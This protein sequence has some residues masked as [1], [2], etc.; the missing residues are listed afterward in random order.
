MLLQFFQL[1][2]LLLW[3]VAAV[4][5]AAASTSTSSGLLQGRVRLVP[6]TADTEQHYA[7][8]ALK[9]LSS[10]WAWRPSGID[11]VLADGAEHCYY[12][13]P[14]AAVN[15][16]YVQTARAR[17][18]SWPVLCHQSNKQI[19]SWA[20]INYS[21]GPI[22][23]QQI[24]VVTKDEQ[25]PDKQRVSNGWQLQSHQQL[26][27][28]ST[29]NKDVLHP[30]DSTIVTV[31]YT[32]SCLHRLT[33]STK[34]LAVT[35]GGTVELDLT[36][37]TGQH[38]QLEHNLNMCSMV[39]LA[40]L[41][42]WTDVHQL[43]SVLVDDLNH[44][45]PV[46]E[47]I[48]YKYVSYY[49]MYDTYGHLRYK[50][51][52][53]QGIILC[54]LTGSIW[55]F[56]LATAIA[57]KYALRD[58]WRMFKARRKF[59]LRKYK[60]QLRP[61]LKAVIQKIIPP[62]QQEQQQETVQ[63]STS[64]TGAAATASG[65]VSKKAAKRKAKAQ[66]TA[67]NKQKQQEK[68]RII[69]QQLQ[70]KLQLKRT[71]PLSED[72]D[73][74]DIDGHDDTA[75]DAA[76]A[77]TGDYSRASGNSNDLDDIYGEHDDDDDIVNDGNDTSDSIKNSRSSN[78]SAAEVD[79]DGATNDDVSDDTNDEK[80][81]QQTLSC[82]REIQSSSNCST[83]DASSTQQDPTTDTISE[84]ASTTG[85]SEPDAIVN[86]DGAEQQ[87][88][89]TDT[90]NTIS[91][92]A[93]TTVPAAAAAVLSLEEVEAILLFKTKAKRTVNQPQ[94]SAAA[95]T[96]GAAKQTKRQ[97]KKSDSSKHDVISGHAATDTPAAAAAA[98]AALAVPAF[99][100][101]DVVY[102]TI[103]PPPG[104]ISGIKSPIRSPVKPT[105]ATAAATPNILPLTPTAAP[106]TAHS[107][108]ADITLLNLTDSDG[109]EQQQHNINNIPPYTPT[110]YRDTA[111]ALLQPQTTV[112]TPLQQQKHQ[113][114]L[115]DAVA[116]ASAAATAIDLESSELLSDSLDIGL[117]D[118]L[119]LDMKH[120]TEDNDDDDENADGFDDNAAVAQSTTNAINSTP[121][122][123]AIGRQ[124]Q[125]QQQPQQQGN[126][127]IPFTRPTW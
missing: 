58:T 44:S 68:Q 90:T 22:A 2:L 117:I 107:N 69:K 10:D 57:T 43:W 1:C 74:D 109:I 53:A 92:D 82:C 84:T 89:D 41:Q 54:L 3:A 42:S 17:L 31:A 122:N 52:R 119:D 121:T 115:A 19:Y 100:V 112:Y 29:K 88:H 97:S 127:F 96:T 40:P 95:A 12:A 14:A 50:T 18:L 55:L 105:V 81:E 61:E 8:N 124:Q 70:Q 60:Q 24:G 5:A 16:T 72:V 35:D 103:A 99:V 75:V 7:E 104:F 114:L 98:A 30:G 67:L 102:N 63:Q 101:R 110:S 111:N 94:T 4:Q 80:Q 9:S 78:S 73:D 65:G 86:D 15:S 28:K 87:Q 106:L 51:E 34:L 76:A 66:S 47:E 32:P 49:V 48:L 125:H 77:I 56:Y 79:H 113:Q 37:A 33:A 27:S 108:S 120:I 39:Q 20:I 126:T 46:N 93:V 21:D 45:L 26:S 91:T 11:N 71:T 36:A 118:Y 64:S 62:I 85:A 123:R 13:P 116:T 23:L 59:F 25:L 83:S 38:S 6:V